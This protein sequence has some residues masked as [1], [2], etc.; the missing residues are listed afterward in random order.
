M[1]SDEPR[2]FAG[3]EPKESPCFDPVQAAFEQIRRRSPNP[4]KLNR[5]A[6]AMRPNDDAAR[7][8]KRYER[9][10]EE[11]LGYLLKSPASRT[12]R[13]AGPDGRRPR[14][15]LEIPSL[16]MAIRREV[17]TRG[18]EDDLAHGWVMGHWEA[19]V[20]ERIAKHSTPTKIVDHIVHVACDNSNWATELRYLQREILKRIAQR[21]GPD[22]I[23]EL[24]IHGPKQHKNY[25][26]PQWVKP[27][28]S[29][30]TYG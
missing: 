27:R 13:Q 14:P 6:A 21:I 8:A 11:T 24:R 7:T 25:D 19:V 4:P 18:W 20:G 1:N 30:D 2:D 28:G 29:R 26:G 16:G 15:S 12:A 9:S 22:I 17:V 5:P 10:A 3:T 23:V